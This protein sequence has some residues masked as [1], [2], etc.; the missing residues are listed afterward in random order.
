VGDYE[1]RPDFGDADGEQSAPADAAALFA[2]PAAEAEPSKDEADARLGAEAAAP[3]APVRRP[4]RLTAGRLAAIGG[5][6]AL[7]VAA[8]VASAAMK[9]SFEPIYVPA[10]PAPRQS[11]APILDEELRQRMAQLRDSLNQV[12][13]AG[14]PTLSPRLWE[15]DQNEVEKARELSLQFQSRTFC[16]LADRLEVQLAE[17]LKLCADAI[18]VRAHLDRWRAQLD[19][20]TNSRS[21]LIHD[22]HRSGWDALR[23][24]LDAAERRFAELKMQDTVG[25]LQELA[26]SYEQE[27]WNALAAA[28]SR[29][30]SPSVKLEFLAQLVLT[31]R[32]TPQQEQLFG[33][34][35]RANQAF[36]LEH[37]DAAIAGSSSREEVFGKGELAAAL[38]SLDQRKST[39]AWSEARQAARQTSDAEA[40]SECWE[41][42]LELAM[43]LH[44]PSAADAVLSDLAENP[45]PKH[46]LGRILGYALISSESAA[47]GRLAPNCFGDSKVAPASMLETM[48]IAVR[49]SGDYTSLNLVETVASGKS[50]CTEQLCELAMAAAERGDRSEFE[51]QMDQSSISQSPTTVAHRLAGLAL[52]GEYEQ[53]L[54]RLADLLPGHDE[55]VALYAALGAARADDEAGATRALAF[56][57]PENLYRVRVVREL[58]KRR[59]LRQAGHAAAAYRW[60][61]TLPTAA[62]RCAAFAWLHAASHDAAPDPTPAASAG[63]VASAFGKSWRGEIANLQSSGNEG[64]ST[65]RVTMLT[66]S[67]S[68]QKQTATVA[69]DADTVGLGNSIS[70]RWVWIDLVDSRADESP[71]R[72]AA[73]ADACYLLFRAGERLHGWRGR[74]KPGFAPSLASIDGILQFEV[75]GTPTQDEVAELVSREEEH[76]FAA[77]AFADNRAKIEIWSSQ[78][79][80]ELQPNQQVGRPRLI[81][82]RVEGTKL[83]TKLVGQAVDEINGALPPGFALAV[84]KQPLVIGNTSRPSR[85]LLAVH[86]CPLTSHHARAKALYGIND[87]P[88]GVEHYGRPM[89]SR[90]SAIDYAAIMVDPEKLNEVELQPA[91]LQDLLRALGVGS[92]TR[93]C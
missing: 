65:S 52:L 74:C 88:M 85:G 16:S 17:H 23:G 3:D 79:P 10:P 30:E 60:A 13:A 68:D 42:L 12:S 62:E 38:N 76:A 72:N 26:V 21:Q 15:A 35:A 66:R 69:I 6:I 56:V 48:A 7:P 44:Q 28:I 49:H 90:D 22:H 47:W 11:G 78:P 33:E 87:W 63:A 58:A 77:L 36:W 24:L 51:R 93:L 37:A 75:G 32:A 31:N 41:R 64:A 5:I 19:H 81:Y 29:A 89:H 27:Y 84:D 34:I 9:Q 39:Q 1:I 25:K 59:P 91:L 70:D 43:D 86:F 55:F 46:S 67:P 20:M 82:V 45:P 61:S 57:S 2:K 80:R 71:R 40:R 18:P 92:R 14:L 83:Q 53:A 50:D 8:L 4:R 73:A 54:E